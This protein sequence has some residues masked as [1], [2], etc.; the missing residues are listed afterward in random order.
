M[1]GFNRI[2][3]SNSFDPAGKEARRVIRRQQFP[4]TKSTEPN[5]PAQAFQQE[6]P[7]FNLPKG[8]IEIL[9]PGID[10]VP[11]YEIAMRD[12]LLFVLGGTFSA[13]AGMS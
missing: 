7:D 8:F 2:P 3:D 13:R 6:L 10:A 12:R 9:A 1:L 4:R 11:A 5:L